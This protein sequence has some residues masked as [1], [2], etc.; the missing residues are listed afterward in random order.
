MK[1]YIIYIALLIAGLV[2]GYVFFGTSSEGSANTKNVSD[3]SETQIQMWTCSMHPQIMQPEPG[4]CPICGMDLIPAESSAEG[5]AMNEIKMT[6][7]AMALANIQ[8]TVVGNAAAS[9]ADGMISLSGKIAA[10]EENNSVQ[11]S[12]FDGR[13]ER[14]NVNYEGQQINR[15]QLLATIY[16]PNL[17]AAQQELLTTASLKESQPALYKAV[18][19]K[20]KNWKLSDQQIDAIESSGNVRDNFPIYA[21]VSG[22]VSEVMAREGD[23]V[24]QGQPILKVSNLNSVWAEFDAYE[25]QISNLKDGQ[26]IK[27]VANAY[28][29]KE[30]DASVSFIDPLLN[31]ATR[32]VTVRATLK[33]TEDLFKPGMFVTGKLKG[34]MKT[35]AETLTVPAS[36]VMWTGERSLVYIK[37]NPN[38]PVFEMR[39]VTIGNR[40]GEFYT[41]TQGLQNG[42]E[43]VTNGTFTVDAAAQLQGKKSMMNQ[44]KTVKET[45]PMADMKIELSA[46][47]QK[48]F[49]KV[50]SPYLQMKDAFV[51]SDAA[52]VSIF[53][54]ATSKSLKSIE[55]DAL[56]KMEQSH[57]I[58]SIEML[59][60]IAINDKLENQ[61]AHFVI[62]NE[63]IIPIAVNLKDVNPILY[64]QK[65]PMANNN[66]GA[67]WLSTEEDIRNP[68][69][70]EQM[71]TCGSVIDSVQ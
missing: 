61:R 31:N 62:L 6:E 37:T 54:K 56:G 35:T 40:N 47:F 63:N 23:Y 42:D 46:S 65:C 67:V 57:I 3:T 52:Q 71:M 20:L 4:D 45:M 12:Y 8:T 27:V 50:F 69:Y 16:S 53:A 18:R 43:I 51:D 48:N 49:T 58:K 15:G 66:K 9:D 28:P 10:N 7:N 36:A 25:N 60:A 1:K 70:G 17:V 11:A 26:K 29:N 41:I 2:L 44:G 19:N 14:L 68:Y 13:I 34:A 33:N 24:K 38:L 39:G 55:I 30:F 22:T 32:T 64:V 21:T 59:D 5:L